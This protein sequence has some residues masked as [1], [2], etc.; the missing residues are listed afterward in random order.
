LSYLPSSLRPSK[1]HGLLSAEKVIDIEVE[2]SEAKE[3][4]MNGGNEVHRKL[5]LEMGQVE[6][7]VEIETREDAFGLR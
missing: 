5:E 7:E 4:I 6:I 1:I 2:A 3:R